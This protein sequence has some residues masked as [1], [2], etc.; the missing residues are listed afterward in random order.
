MKFLG[1][2]GG[3]RDL[4]HHRTE[5][6]MFIRPEIIRNGV[7]AEN[8]TKDMALELRNMLAPGSGGVSISK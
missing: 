1:N 2:I 7:D 3:K 8:V 6:V 5:L 4:T